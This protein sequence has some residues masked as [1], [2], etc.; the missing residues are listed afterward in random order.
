MRLFYKG[1]QWAAFNRSEETEVN[2]IRRSYVRKRDETLSLI[3]RG[4]L[5]IID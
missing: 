5:A 2:A 4:Y 1:T 3:E